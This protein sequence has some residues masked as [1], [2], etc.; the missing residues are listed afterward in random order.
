MNQSDRRERN[1]FKLRRAMRYTLL[2]GSKI[3][4]SGSGCTL[5]ISSKGAAFTTP[6][7]LR[8]GTAIEISV[9]WPALL[10]GNCPIRLVAGGYVVRSTPRTAACRI[11]KFQ[12]RTQANAESSVREID[13]STRWRAGKL[14][15]RA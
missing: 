13:T 3:I 12:F 2:E 9:S 14:P 4:G 10:D 5:D 1:R 8:P 6:E 11:C 7:R 15:F